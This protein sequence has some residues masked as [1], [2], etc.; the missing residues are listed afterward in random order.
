MSKQRYS[1][2]NYSH[3]LNFF[4][5]RGICKQI[6][7]TMRTYNKQLPEIMPKGYIYN[8]FNEFRLFVLNDE[9]LYNLALKFGFKE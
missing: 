6:Y 1:F 5:K 2:D 7:S 3:M 4:E 9:Y 8:N